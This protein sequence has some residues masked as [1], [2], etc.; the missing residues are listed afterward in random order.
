VRIHV[1]LDPDI[2]GANGDGFHWDRGGAQEW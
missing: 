2:T 1:Y